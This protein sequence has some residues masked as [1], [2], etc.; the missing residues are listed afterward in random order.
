MKQV[1]FLL[2]FAIFLMTAIQPVLAQDS[3]VKDTLAIGCPIWSNAGLGDTFRVPVYLY[4][5]QSLDEVSFT[6][7]YQCDNLEFAGAELNRS[8]LCNPQLT[9]DLLIYPLLP[10]YTYSMYLIG[11]QEWGHF[12]PVI[13]SAPNRRLFV[14]LLFIVTDLNCCY[15]NLDTI[16]VYGQGSTYFSNYRPVF[17]AC[18]GQGI[19]INCPVD[20]DFEESVIVPDAF[21][22]QN[23]PNP[24]NSGT[25]IEL[26]M[27]SSGHLSILIYDILGR[28]VRTIVDDFIQ[29]GP[30]Q[31]PWDGKSESGQSAASGVYF[32]RITIGSDHVVRKLV[33][34]R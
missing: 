3:G 8:I 1:V 21:V 29:R 6:F 30:H 28:H 13:W 25:T 34:L 18:S 10:L 9:G 5:D 32:A 12:P 33:L 23:F 31:F 26:D 15:P 14:N 27:P 7:N 4:T 22:T 20:V 2:T 16:R 17:V 11:H 19:A 24:F